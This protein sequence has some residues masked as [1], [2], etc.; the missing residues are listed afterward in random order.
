[1]VRINKKG[2]KPGGRPDARK[3]GK[4][5]SKAKVNLIFSKINHL[6]DTPPSKVNQMR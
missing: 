5:T 2:G 6:G 3:A 1:M 4:F